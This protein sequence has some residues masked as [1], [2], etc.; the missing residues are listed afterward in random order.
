MKSSAATQTHGLSS[1][2]EQIVNVGQM[3]HDS[4]AK[5]QSKFAELHLNDAS[6]RG[7]H[8]KLRA[9]KKAVASMW[10][11]KEIEG[12]EENLKRYEGLFRSVM[13]H[14]VCK[15]VQTIEIRSNQNFQQLNTG[16]QSFIIKL[17]DDCTK[18]SE[19]SLASL[20]TRCQMA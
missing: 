4:M 5:L 3:L 13:L 14:C 18:I 15:Q 1:D 20:E 16:L 17:V 11:S 10:Y 9:G 7:I 12:L 8:G 2:Q 19:L 6:K